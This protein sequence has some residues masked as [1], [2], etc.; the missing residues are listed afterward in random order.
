DRQIMYAQVA[1]IALDE[2][3][4]EATSRSIQE[5][6]A[7]DPIQ[8]IFIDLVNDLATKDRAAADKLILQCM[9]NLSAVQLSDSFNTGRAYLVAMWLI[10]PNSFF[11]DP[12][13]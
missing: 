7:I 5:N 8:T 6:M 3:N 2:G 12:N 10:F 4:N 13:K 9:A 1:R 11:P